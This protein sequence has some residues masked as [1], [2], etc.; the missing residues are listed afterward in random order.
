MCP[1]YVALLP[2][3]DQEPSLPA[4]ERVAAQSAAAR[5][6]LALAAQSAECPEMEFLKH[7]GVP[8]PW[9]GWHWSISHDGTWVLGALAR[10]PLGVDLERVTL[11]RAALRAAVLD[12]HERALLG[13]VNALGFTRLWTAKEA[14]L[15]AAGV[16]LTRLSHCR[17]SAPPPTDLPQAGE[18]TG[19]PLGMHLDGQPTPVLQFRWH[20]H[21]LAIHV[22]GGE[23]RLTWVLPSLQCV[24]CP[25]P[26]DHV[27]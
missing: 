19:P 5:C 8:Q 20:D 18:P 26:Q 15:K 25:E 1:T 7:D 10:A 16:G 24:S 4:R 23:E 12:E 17:L 3:P 6:A 27:T 21:V 9:N 13:E 22:R 2:T 11:R 14:V